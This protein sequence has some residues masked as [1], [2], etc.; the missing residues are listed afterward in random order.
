[1]T[2]AFLV[3]ILTTFGFYTLASLFGFVIDLGLY[4]KDNTFLTGF[5]TEADLEV[6]ITLFE[7]FLARE[8]LAI[9]FLSFYFFSTT[10]AFNFSCFSLILIFKSFLAAFS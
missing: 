5:T 7:D 8:V 10:L 6:C 4:F 1:L 2:I 3:I 9:S